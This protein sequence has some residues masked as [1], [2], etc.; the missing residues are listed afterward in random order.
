M[1][2]RIEHLAWDSEFLGRRV[3]RLNLTVAMPLEVSIELAAR[4]GY[5]LLYVYSPIPIKEVLIGKYVFLDVGGHVIF[6]WNSSGHSLEE[7]QYAPE[8]CEYQLDYLTPELLEIAFLSGHLSRFKVDSLLPAGSYERL[9]ETWLANTVANRPRAVIFAYHYDDRIAGI[10]TAEWHGAKCSIG[11][12]AVLQPYQGQ[13]IGAKL[14]RHLQDVC[15]PNKA[16]SVEVKTQLSNARAIA[17]YLKNSFAERERF[18]LYH[19]HNFGQSG[20]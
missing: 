16:A 11:L 8:I 17:F 1:F 4:Q 6:S 9:Y 20:L 14:I 15:I 13:G 2:E 12:L 5:E 18:F 19:A 7:V 3:G 10:I